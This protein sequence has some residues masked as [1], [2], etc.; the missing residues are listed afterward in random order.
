MDELFAT[1]L[2][3]MTDV[4]LRQQTVT[5]LVEARAAHDGQK[6]DACAAEARRRGKDC[7]Y[8]HAYVELMWGPDV[9]DQVQT[10]CCLLPARSHQVA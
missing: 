3:R 6:V 7:L 5:A 9:A 4:E 1:I 8:G 10:L 2:A